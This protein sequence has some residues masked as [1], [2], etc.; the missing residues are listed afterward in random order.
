M[1][2]T[3]VSR[4]KF[5]ER[6]N[7]FLARVEMEGQE[8]LCHV[9]N[10]GRCRELLNPGAVVYLQKSDNPNRKTGYDLIAVEKGE[11]LIN[12]DSQIPNYVAAEWLRKGSLFP[13][14]ANIQM[15]K[16]YGNSR[17][18][19]YAEAGERKAFLEVKGV[20]LEVEGQ[21]RFPDAP[22]ERGVKHVRELMGCV[23]EGYEAYLLFVIQMTGIQSFAPNWDTHPAFG[24][25]L[26]EAARAGVQILAYDCQ[27]R[28]D[29]IVLDQPVP[30]LL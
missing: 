17:F 11:M 2:Y 5:L 15:E 10:T 18:D 23:Q 12:M 13:E 3:N 20:T 24:S 6:P 14:G 29:E 21:A 9:K 8:V 30:V 25:A 28:P 1:R 22:T 19:I 27:V 4:C 26:Q 7:R 16:R